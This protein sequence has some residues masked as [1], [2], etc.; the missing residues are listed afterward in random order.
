MPIQCIY[1]ESES[2]SFYSQHTIAGKESQY[3]VR[4]KW[5]GF[6]QNSASF[7][8]SYFPSECCETNRAMIMIT[9]ELFFTSFPLSRATPLDAIPSSPPFRLFLSFH[10]SAK[11]DLRINNRSGSFFRCCGIKVSFPGGIHF[12]EDESTESD[13]TGIGREN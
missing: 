3:R 9:M 10:R 7:S 13:T 5:Y 2:R 1:K 12:T 8:R 11:A 4:W 6:M